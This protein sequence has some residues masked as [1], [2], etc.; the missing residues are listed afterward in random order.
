MTQLATDQ[1]LTLQA[2]QAAVD[3]YNQRGIALPEAIA[4]IANTLTPHID[5]L[6]TLAEI[7]PAFDMAYQSARSALQNQSSQRA[8]FIDSTESTFEHPPNGFHLA[9]PQPNNNG[10]STHIAPAT[11]NGHT[12]TGPPPTI[13][14]FVLATDANAVEK[15]YFQQYIAQL[16]QLNPQWTVTLDACST[17][18]AEAYVMFPQDENYKLNRA[19]YAAAQI[20]TQFFSPAKI[21]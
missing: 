3:T 12:K 11:T 4:T 13:K 2:F 6:D 15:H 7:D 20:V 21:R 10:H 19:A 18:E 8:K 14:R 16:K 5:R 9:D 17:G 1:Q